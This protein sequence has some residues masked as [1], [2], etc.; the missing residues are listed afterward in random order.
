M[1]QLGWFSSLLIGGATGFMAFFIGTFVGILGVPLYNGVT[2]HSVDMS[3]SYKGVG[4][5]LGLTVLVL[6][7]GYLGTLWVKRTF[8]KG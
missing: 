5:P 6:A 8:R 1:G 3:W 2:H 7:W 4:L